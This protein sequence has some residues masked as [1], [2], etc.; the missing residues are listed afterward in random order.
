MS[1][2]ATDRWGAALQSGTT[3]GVSLFDAAVQDLVSLSGDPV[4]AAEAAVAADDGLVLGHV[5]RAYL[6]LYGTSADGVSN[7][8]KVLEDLEGITTLGEREVLH[9]RAARSWAGGEWDEAAHLLERAL[10]HDSR[11][12]LALKVA[13]DLYFFLGQSTDILG[14]V[15]RVLGAWPPDRVGWSYVQGMYAFGLEENGDYE[16][17]EIS[18]R[19]ALQKEPRDTW[20]SHALA[21]VFEMQGRQPEGG[22]FLESSSQYWSS[23]FFAVH[24]WWHDALYHLETGDVDRVLSNYDGPIRGTRSTE[25]LDLVDAASLLWRLSLYGH[26]LGDRVR[27]LA[28]DLESVL[29][30]PVYIFDDWHAVMVFGLAGAHDL[31]ERVL[32]ANRRHTFGTN[33]L[34]A[35]QVGL[36]LLEGFS[37]F[38]TGR[39]ARALDLLSEARPLASSVG[40]SH[41]QRDIIDLTLVAAAARAGHDK[42]ARA[43]AA[44]RVAQRPPRQRPPNASCGQTGSRPTVLEPSEP[45]A[46]RSCSAMTTACSLISGTAVVS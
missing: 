45:V 22:A 37:S 12:L 35:E 21:H 10:L 42:T 9:I 16:R 24:N 18:A 44:D 36:T 26:D 17:A 8:R 46:A 39:Y 15:A 28:V 31:T 32:T 11:D 7:A 25:W 43:L 3:Q 23:S 14:V 40:G 1:D 41:A 4:A 27:P 5:L 30:D 38:S 13:Q 33:R 6:H 2:V 19:A 20:A 34:V 29:S